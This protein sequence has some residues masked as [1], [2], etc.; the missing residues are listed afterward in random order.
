MMFQEVRR[1]LAFQHK[2]PSLESLSHLG[3]AWQAVLDFIGLPF[4]IHASSAEAMFWVVR[5][6]MLQTIPKSAALDYTSK[7]TSKM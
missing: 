3:K 7:K 4:H 6:V 1:L 5:L 2:P